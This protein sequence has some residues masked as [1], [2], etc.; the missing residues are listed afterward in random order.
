MQCDFQ[1]FFLKFVYEILYKCKEKV[2][3]EK[4]KRNINFLNAMQGG[5]MCISVFSVFV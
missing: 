5:Y 2:P 1:Y 4:N 3:L